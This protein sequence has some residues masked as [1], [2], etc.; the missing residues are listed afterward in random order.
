MNEDSHCAL[1]E[2]GLFVVAD[3]LGGYEGGEVASELAVRAL[4][5][6][7]GRGLDAIGVEVPGLTE[8]LAA[9]FRDADRKVKEAQTG[10]LG[11][12]QTTLSAVLLGDR[13][14]LVGHVGDSRVY[15]LRSRRLVQVTRDHTAYE[16]MLASGAKLSELD[17][18]LYRNALTRTIG[19]E[20]RVAPD[21]YRVGLEQGDSLLLCTDGVYRALRPEDLAR[22]LEPGGAQEAAIRLVREAERQ[23]G[24]DN[25]T[26]VVVRVQS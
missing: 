11:L 3:G 9:G 22:L 23:T 13:E 24:A 26:A 21:L 20:E 12:M 4:C 1:P 19:M 7:V 15:H 18:Y 8:L 10:P 5:E 6:V 16:E 2:R 25:M 14:A 17:Y